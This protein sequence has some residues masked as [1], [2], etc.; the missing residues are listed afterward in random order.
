MAEKVAMHPAY[1]FDCPA[2]GIE[3]FV[4]AMNFPLNRDDEQEVERARRCLKLDEW[5][6]IPD[7]AFV[8]YPDRVRCGECGEEFDTVGWDED[9]E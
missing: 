9:E 7:G 1:M 5:E 6:E 4:R 2:C 3:N 8:T